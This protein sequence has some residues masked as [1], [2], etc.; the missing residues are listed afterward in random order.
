[1]CLSVCV[2]AYEHF[3]VVSDRDGWSEQGV[4]NSLELPKLEAVVSCHLMWIL[5]RRLR[6]S[7]KA[8]TIHYLVISPAPGTL[9]LRLV[10][11]E[12]LLSSMT[13]TIR[14]KSGVSTLL[15]ETSWEKS[16]N[17]ILTFRDFKI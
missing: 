10:P 3:C 12:V 17:S 7:G 8:S 14:S 13:I 11:A 5:G 1:M 2:C 6:S 4:S 9:C 15:L 16:L